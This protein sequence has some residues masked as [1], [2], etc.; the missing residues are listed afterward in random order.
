[1]VWLE[2]SGELNETGMVRDLSDLQQMRD[3]LAN[4]YDHRHL[5][6]VVDF[7]PTIE[8]LASHLYEIADGFLGTAVHAVR[9]EET[10]T[11]WARYQ[12]G[13]THLR[14]G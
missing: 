6:D 1:M 10:S 14:I 9:V 7:P 13:R 4:V 12:P 11:S 8:C 3:Y 5:N 2:L